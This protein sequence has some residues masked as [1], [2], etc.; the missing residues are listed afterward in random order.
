LKVNLEPLVVLGGAGSGIIVVEAIRAA[1]RTAREVLGFLND[2]EAVGARLADTPVL[3]TFEQWRDCP[4]NA[5]FISAFP[6]VKESFNRY[7]RLQSLDIPKNR[8]ATV[9]HPS[10]S[11]AHGVVIGCGS[12]VGAGAVIEPGV[13]AGAHVCIRG[14]SYISHDVRLGDYVFVGPNVTILGRSLV[15]EGAYIAAN[16]VCR[17]QITIGRYGVVGIGSVVVRDTADFAVVAGNPA[18]IVD[19]GDDGLRHARPG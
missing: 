13:V 14:G 5:N 18:R 2:V 11:V 10:A 12:F 17:D 16:S 8:W 1:G 4:A 6:G 3:G 19:D 7:R 9:I 15:R